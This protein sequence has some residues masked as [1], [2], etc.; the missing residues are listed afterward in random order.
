MLIR[1]LER[2]GHV[3]IPAANGQEGVDIIKEDMTKSKADSSHI[4]IDSIQMDYEMPMLRGPEA[5]A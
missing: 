1:L 2:A 3:R 4:P 5:S